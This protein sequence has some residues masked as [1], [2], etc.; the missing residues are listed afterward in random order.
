M[1]ENVGSIK[2]LYLLELKK[3]KSIVRF[4]GMHLYCPQ[5]TL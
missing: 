5:V 4:F 1:P 2:S 3:N